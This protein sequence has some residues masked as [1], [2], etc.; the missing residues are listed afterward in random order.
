MTIQFETFKH[1]SKYVIG[2]LTQDKPD[3]FNDVISWRK[4]VVTV[5]MVEEPVEVL[6]ARLQEMWDTCEN[7]H[8][9][10][11]IKAEAK[12]LGYEIAGSPGSRRVK[13]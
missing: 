12:K 9:W 1:P 4:H 11:A 5:E 8:H 6:T 2:L 3:V 7:S 13:K 10:N